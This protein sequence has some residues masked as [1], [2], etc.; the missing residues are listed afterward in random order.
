MYLLD[1]GEQSNVGVLVEQCCH[2]TT[3]S[4]DNDL[5]MILLGKIYIYIYIHI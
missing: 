2:T 4:T 3:S 1:A 5:C